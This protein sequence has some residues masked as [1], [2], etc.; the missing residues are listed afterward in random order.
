VLKDNSD[1]SDIISNVS[2]VLNIDQNQHVSFRC[3]DVEEPMHISTGESNRSTYF[4]F[5]ENTMSSPQ[6]S[7]LQT[8][9]VCNRYEEEGEE[10]KNP[11]Q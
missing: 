9:A 7:N 4:R 2:V 11:Y 1:I 8:K 3:I 5:V 10:L 6:L